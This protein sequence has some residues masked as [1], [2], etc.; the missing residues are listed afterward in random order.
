MAEFAQGRVGIGFGINMEGSDS[1]VIE[2]QIDFQI[3]QIGGIEQHLL[4]HFID[5]GVEHVHR[6]I[7][8][9]EFQILAGRQGDGG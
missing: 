9:S 7:H 3:E 1:S 6:S 4:L 2:D 8:V 5:G